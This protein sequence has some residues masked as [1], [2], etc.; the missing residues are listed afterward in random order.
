MCASVWVAFFTLRVFRAEAI[1]AKVLAG[2]NVLLFVVGVSLSALGGDYEG[3]TVSN[4]W[5][6][7]EW[8][9]YTLPYVWL[10]AEA[11][12]AYRRAR[13]RQRIGLANAM[14]T[15]RYLLWALYGTLSVVAK[16]PAAAGG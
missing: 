13:K 14:V 15:N 8:C 9:G 12:L 11:I 2:A 16:A 10:T 5:F 3:Y 6:W 1:W 7:L 4:P